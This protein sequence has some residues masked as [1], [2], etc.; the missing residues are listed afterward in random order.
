MILAPED[1]NP[2]QADTKSGRTPLL[3]AAENGH[4]GVVEMLLERNDVHTT[5]PDKQNQTSL[6]LALYNGHHEVVRIL[7]ERDNVY[8]NAVDCRSP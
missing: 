6:S 7:A 8:S 2:N 1:V 4:E 3:W 5:T